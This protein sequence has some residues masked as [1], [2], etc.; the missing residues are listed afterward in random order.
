MVQSTQA[1]LATPTSEQPLV[2]IFMFCRN[3]A[4]HI[5]RAI[6]SILAQTYPR[7]EVI[8]QDGAS[9]DGT[10]DILAEY[11]DRLDV[12]SR[13]DSGT[14]EA[15]LAALRRCK[16]E[17]I[18]SCL[19]DETLQPE[20]VDIAL[21]TFRQRG[22]LDAVTGDAL[23]TDADG[24]GIGRYTGRDFNLI[25]Y[26]ADDYCPYF[27]ASFFRR[28]FLVDHGLFGDDWQKEC[29]EFEIW[30]RLATEGQ[31]AYVPE[32]LG[33]YALHAGQESNN[34]VSV[35]RNLGDRMRVFPRLFAAD[36]FLS[37]FPPFVMPELLLKHLIAHYNHLFPQCREDPRPLAYL[38]GIMQQVAASI[39]RYEDTASNSD[40][41]APTPQLHAG[42]YRHIVGATRLPPPIRYR[43]VYDHWKSRLAQ[44]YEARGMPAMAMAA[45]DRQGS[46]YTDGKAI[47]AALKIPW[48]DDAWL[49]ERQKDWV[50]R[51][52]AKPLR[53]ETPLKTAVDPARIR[54]GY[55]CVEWTLTYTRFQIVPFVRHRSDRFE[56]VCYS[57]AKVPDDLRDAFD[58]VADNLHGES[59]ADFANRLRADGI[60]LFVEV[61]G[62]G[63]GQRFAAMAARA[64]PVQ[65]SYVNHAG[66]TGV[67]NVDYVI[68]D[69]TAV[70]AT[71]DA[72][73]SETVW[74]LP[75]CFFCF[76][77]GEDVLPAIV[78]PPCLS[79]GAVTF[80]FFGSPVKLNP[81]MIGLWS[82]IL[83]EVPGSRLIAGGR[84]LDHRDTRRR[85][86]RQFEERG[87]SGGRLLVHGG[88]AQKRIV[89]LY[90]R[91]DVSFDSWPYC[92][93]N[94]LAESLWMGVP[95]V[96]LLGD[97][98][99]ARYGASILKAS[100]LDDLVAEDGDAYVAKAVALARDPRRLRHLR[101][102][103][104]GMLV[105]HGFGDPVAFAAK[106]DQA[107]LGMLA[108]KGY[109]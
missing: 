98:F 94:T 6:D 31:I 45:H 42:A 102:N 37:D 29:I 101:D 100:G 43:L 16:G 24:N 55:Y 34:P 60:D 86:F 1:G 89:D 39:L 63:D 8:V 2:S 107:Y 66:T 91:I 104:R 56:A 52:L 18:G 88:V 80:G 41:Y 59:D 50:D 9:T 32:V 33:S 30:C 75:G 27:V 57:N 38:F 21:A 20:A 61:N 84:G 83:A 108:D 46:R 54:V 11:G 99:A 78:P 93:G 72:H 47:Q 77:Y 12:V 19:A 23:Q 105:A 49:A 67:P 97:R 15:F 96:S 64:A 35:L 28:R 5:R 65:A 90:S 79:S 69:A 95:A 81:A 22:G 71:S 103:L 87:I 62:F 109:L 40:G 73:Y 85:L 106:M 74:R 3:G 82:R 14:N 51:H 17:V 76:H 10:L 48:A 25:D 44:R 13:P 58:R 53:V 26:L 92:G 36:G 4:P 7:I 68:A 70:E